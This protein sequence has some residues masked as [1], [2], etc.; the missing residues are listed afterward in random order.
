MP[1]TKKKSKIQ[2]YKKLQT[3]K[4]ITKNNYIKHKFIIKISFKKGHLFS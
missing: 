3:D 2:T 4:K 1:L